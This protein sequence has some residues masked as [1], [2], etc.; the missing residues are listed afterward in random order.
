[1]C[2]N[3]WLKD[4]RKI[5]LL[6]TC[7]IINQRLTLTGLSKENILALPNGSINTAASVNSFLNLCE[8]VKGAQLYWPY[9]F[10]RYEMKSNLI[11]VIF[12]KYWNHKKKGQIRIYIIYSNTLKKNTLL[13][14]LTGNL[15]GF[16]PEKHL[17][18]IMK[19]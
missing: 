18:L 1:M 3:L 17:A 13:C 15:I 2:Q 10:W 6:K 16:I 8:D 11:W 4:S 9:V 7:N 5:S 12:E 14:G 19:N